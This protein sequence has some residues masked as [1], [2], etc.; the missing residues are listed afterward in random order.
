MTENVQKLFYFKQHFGQDLLQTLDIKKDESAAAGFDDQFPAFGGGVFHCDGGSQVF[1]RGC[2]SFAAVVADFRHCSR[3]VEMAAD[4]I[5]EDRG[6]I[7]GQ[8]ARASR[9]KSRAVR[10]GR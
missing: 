4:P 8:S 5:Y 10:K 7:S 2:Q 6:S 1:D 3:A 9:R